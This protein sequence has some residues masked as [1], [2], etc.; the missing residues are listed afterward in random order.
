MGKRLS[1]IVGLV[2]ILL[3]CTVKAAA[4]MSMPD[5]VCV[6]ATKTYSVN[7]PTVPSTYTWT[8]N[9]VTQTTTGNA[10]TVTWSVV[11]TYLITVQEHS[12]AG[13]DGDIQSG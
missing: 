7:D 11:G 8:I 1:Y 9:G 4:Q 2:F 3:L 12:A 10:L 6:G 5:N 13:C